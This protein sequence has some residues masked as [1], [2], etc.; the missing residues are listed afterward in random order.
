MFSTEPS[1]RDRTMGEQDLELLIR[2][3][4][5]DWRRGHRPLIDDYLPAGD[6]DRRAVL[7]ELV[8]ADLELRLRA[9]EPAR[10]EEY[11]AR[12]PELVGESKEVLDL[13]AAECNLRRER[14]PELSPLA[15]QE[16]F[17]GLPVCL[18]SDLKTANP[19]ATDRIEPP[20][21]SATP[22][23]PGFRIVG[24]VGSGAMG[25]VYRAWDVTLNRPVA[26]K[27]ILDN[28]RVSARQM[29]RFQAE[30][31]AMARLHHPHIVQ[32]FTC[33]E[34]EGNPY[35]AME[36]V[37]GPTLARHLDHQPQLPGVA[38]RLVYLLARAVHAAHQKGIV[39]RDL[40]P[41]NVLLAPA[42]GEPALNS[43]YGCP[44][45]A[46]FG[47]ARVRAAEESPPRPG[48]SSGVIM[49]T[50]PYMAP[51]QARGNTKAI[52]P[53]TDVYALGAILYELLTGRPPFQG[54][55]PMDTLAQVVSTSP[56]PPSCLQMDIPSDLEAICL[57]CLEKEPGDR[58]A[59]AAA[60]AEDLQRYLNNECSVSRT[61]SSAFA[62]VE[63][64]AIVTDLA[65]Q[66]DREVSTKRRWVL[67]V[68]GAIALTLAVVLPLSMNFFDDKKPPPP[69]SASLRISHYRG[70]K[71]LGRLGIASPL[72]RLGDDV[73]VHAKLSE[74]AHIYLIA[75]TADGKEELCFP[76][77]ATAKP[78]RVTTISFPPTPSEYFELDQGEGWHAFMLLAARSPLPSYH[79]WR[80]DKGQPPW[81]KANAQKG[82]W[83]FD[84]QRF[85]RLDREA[86]ESEEPPRSMVDLCHFFKNQ[87]EF[88]IIRCVVFS[89][90]PREEGKQRPL[91]KFPR[92]RALIQR[93]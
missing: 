38:A 84:G 35:L 65:S 55:T 39:H 28:D 12:Y 20:T 5:I 89:I 42:M 44:K 92:L 47:L 81:H 31:Q 70:D 54:A 60:L 50:P 34:H 83:T 75:F 17:P 8:H 59:S 51:E 6:R 29:Q 87:P 23:I 13:I 40:K 52:G 85:D 9:G 19:K 79:E 57:R 76:A 27:L 16:R 43:F 26:L 10:V 69:L 1:L 41:G 72:P 68:A 86:P 80:A 30:G 56:T 32:I 58:P 74:P 33:G 78:Q 93:L 64:T 24:E 21:L 73:R 4:E 88:E 11:L 62:E 25:V 90:L 7:V 91:R 14:E 46:D 45:I 77:G 48:T 22:S 18:G 61:R 82:V 36:L 37:D 3:F 53:A 15:Y 67:R 71:Q 63:Q 49:G 2:S 66:I